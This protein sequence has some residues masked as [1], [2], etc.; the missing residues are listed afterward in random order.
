MW[1]DDMYIF[2]N[3]HIVSLDPGFFRW[4]FSSFYAANWHPLTWISHAL[5]FAIWGLNPF[6][7]HLTNVIIH[8]LNTFVVVI[9]SVRLVETYKAG[10][11]LEFLQ[12][13]GTMIAAAVTGLLF[14]IHPLHVESV[15]W[16]S[17]RKDVLCGLFFL[18]GILSYTSY[19][20]DQLS[21]GVMKEATAC[22]ILS[23]WYLLTIVFFML[24]LL[25][26]PMAVSFPL[27]LLIVDR[28]PFERIRSAR[29]LLS[30]L[31]EKVPLIVLS[32]IS[33]VVTFM[34]Q[35]SG[36]SV[37]SIETAPLTARVLIASGSLISYLSKMMVPLNLNPFYPYPK[38][39][40]FSSPEFLFPFLLAAGITAATL[41]YIRRQKFFTSVWGYYLVTLAPV[42][43]LVQ[44]GSQAMADRYTYLPAIGPFLAAGIGMAWVW[45][46][47]ERVDTKFLIFRSFGFCTVILLIIS[48]AYS[49]IRQIAV[50][51]NSITLWS[52]VI[53]LGS[54]KSALAYN[55]RGLAF[56]HMGQI[57]R[58]IQDF[59]SAIAADPYYYK[60]YDN[61]AVAY[62]K[63]KRFNE[64]LKAFDKSI[65]IKSDNPVTY[66]NRAYAHYLLHEN[67]MAV[68]DFSKA[69]ALDR[70]YAR[71]YLNR[72]V[73]YLSR[74]N[75]DLAV[76]DFKKACALGDK[77]GCKILRLQGF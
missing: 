43:G 61:L 31:T 50:W 56:S 23:K 52:Y 71:A 1:D 47:V 34:A 68:E 11:P 26:K 12:G 7:H 63:A 55:N 15:A 24:A 44:V 6:G 33:A 70:N 21:A 73:L 16:V 13:K 53:E 14:G 77:E 67:E 59:K 28:Y 49:A 35:K 2:E 62:G 72:G 37:A 17:E 8:S 75:K 18:S 30:A 58:A 10:R 36:D 46:K 40:S 38:H 3:Q 64:A 45:K 51:K 57:D 32:L 66:Y 39:P 60:S 74:Q 29:T 22:S 54:G 5:D 19:A 27:V 4:A 20:K 48:L 9:L 42:L 69:I 76:Q 65:S 41:I 25:S